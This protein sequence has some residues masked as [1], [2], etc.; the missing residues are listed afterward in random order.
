MVKNPLAVN[1]A[2]VKF[3]NPL[4]AASGTFGYGLEYSEIYDVSKIGGISLKGLTLLPKEGN[5]SPRIAETPSGIL[6]SVGL[7]NPGTKAFVNDYMPKIKKLGTVL[8][9]NIAGNT[10][11][12]YAQTAKIVS[13]SGVDMIELNISCPNVKQ[14]G[15]AFGVE[16]DSVRAVTEKVKENSSLP[17]IVK[18][19][20]NVSD[21]TKNAAAA[22]K[23]GADAISLINTI[24]GMAVDYKTRRPVLKNVT[25]GL[26][27]PAVK[28]V[29]LKMVWQVYNTVDIPIIG[30]GGIMSYTDVLEFIICGAS[31]VQIGTANIYNPTAMP[32]I[33]AD[34][35]RYFKENNL[36]LEELK[37]TLIV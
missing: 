31:A 4:I 12:E 11:E 18:L 22:Q 13:A 35:E 3:K 29:A 27:G 10:L 32:E 14:G 36:T 21:I 2:G 25:G 9:A 24:S 20:P 33:L 17:L 37:G 34:L 19:T 7:Q 15:M 23:G 30:M 1:I 28:P 26:S 8:I 6:N 16:P 5:D